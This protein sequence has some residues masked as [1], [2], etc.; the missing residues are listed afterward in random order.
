MIEAIRSSHAHAF[1]F[2]YAHEFFQFLARRL[3]LLFWEG[4]PAIAQ[5]EFPLIGRH[6]R[7]QRDMPCGDGR[8]IHHADDDFFERIPFVE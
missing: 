1:R 5:V 6:S 8:A 3:D 4:L 7:L 2:E